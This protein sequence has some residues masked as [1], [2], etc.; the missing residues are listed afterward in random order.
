MERRSI[1]GGLTYGSW[2]VSDLSRL[3]AN[4]HPALLRQSSAYYI[5]GMEYDDVGVFDTHASKALEGRFD[6]F[7]VR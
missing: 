5:E 7:A 6:G 1:Q 2:R 4:N 3:T